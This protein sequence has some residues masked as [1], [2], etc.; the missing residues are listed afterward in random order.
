[1]QT[2]FTKY[3]NKKC[4][5]AVL[6]AIAALGI[7]SAC[8]GEGTTTQLEAE[9]TVQIGLPTFL[10]NEPNVN[11][12]NLRPVVTLSN[13]TTVSVNENAANQWSG[14]IRLEA[15]ENYQV[16]VVWVE[17]IN[18][19]ILPLAQ[20]T[21]DL[22]IA[23]DGTTSESN[24]TGYTNDLDFDND[25]ISNFV[26]RRDVSDPF[27]AQTNATPEES[28]S[29]VTSVLTLEL[30]ELLEDKSYIDEDDLRPVITLSDD[31]I[32]NII[33]ESDTE[34][35]G[36]V[37]LEPDVTAQVGIMWIVTIDEM[38]LPLT[39]R[40]FDI[41]VAEDGTNRQRNTTGYNIDLDF[42]EDGA[43][44]IA[45]LRND[46][47]P[48][49][50]EDALLTEAEETPLPIVA[51]VIVPRISASDA[52]EIDGRN[53]VS[54]RTSQF[55]SEWAQAVQNDTS[56]A[57]LTI[58]N[59]LI[60]K[61]AEETNGVVFRRWAAMHDGE[62]LYIVV[63]VDDD[64]KRLRDSGED[65]YNDDSLELFLDAD[66]SKSQTYD[67]NDFHRIYP[68]RRSGSSSKISA[69]DGEM[70]GPNSSSANLQ[71]DFATGPGIGSDG[72]RRANFEQDVYELRVKLDSI[73]LSSEA[74]FGFELQ[75]NDDDD[76]GRR[77]SKW[78]WKNPARESEDRD[79]AT[80]N[81]SFMGTLKLE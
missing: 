48:F 28:T 64:G 3:N 25:G 10:F 40:T 61:N 26:E 27:E 30:P 67:D 59:L 15:G 16:S 79:E 56:G 17:E 24:N 9:P 72:L 2:L 65:V 29:R 52:P 80:N 23:N 5:R 7:L 12:N 8:A 45:E 49:I 55:G 50:D 47:D 33:R 31:S 76:G 14:T 53:V 39:Q 68:V 81:P 35:S 74:A 38:D 19:R 34:W 70:N 69:N 11:N 71:V 75:V 18:G 20:L 4:A 51:D 66:N 77:D 63:T 57:P 54:N 36:V 22:A 42:D 6:V 1:M 60:D 13:G 32:V 46:T 43:S 41:T 21:Y 37:R 58:E 44:N 62:Y 73:D 78:A